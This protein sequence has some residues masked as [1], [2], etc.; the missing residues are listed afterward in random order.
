MC[1]RK[2]RKENRKEK[3]ENIRGVEACYLEILEKQQCVSLKEL[4]V[5]G[6]DLIEVGMS[7][8]AKLGEMLQQLLEKVIEEPDRNQKEELLNDVR[9]HLQNH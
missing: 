8:G 5:S 3:E 4:A 9:S 2:R 6:R 1:E 7:P